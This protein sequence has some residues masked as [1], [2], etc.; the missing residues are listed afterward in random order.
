MIS[1]QIKRDISTKQKKHTKVEP[2][3]NKVLAVVGNEHT[4]NV[5][6]DVV[7][8]LAALEHV[9]GRA[10]GNKE[11]SAEFEL[12]LDREVLDGKMVLPV[13]GNGLVEASVLLVG[14][15]VGV[16]G[17]DGLGLVKDLLLGLGGLDLARFERDQRAVLKKLKTSK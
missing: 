7:A 13:V 5:E 4:A 6:L 11:D 12:T 9:E 10:A 16:A 1:F 2:F 17:P 15:L 8:L 14:D 3:G